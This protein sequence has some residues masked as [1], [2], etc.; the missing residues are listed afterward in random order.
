MKTY[1]QFLFE[2]PQ[3]KTPSDGGNTLN[4]PYFNSENGMM[5]NNTFRKGSK[6]LSKDN[7]ITTVKIGD[8]YRVRDDDT[9]QVVFMS[10]I[11]RNRKTKQIPFAHNT[12]E[13]VAKMSNSILP[14]RFGAN[15]VYNH[16]IMNKN[17]PFVSDEEQYPGG[18]KM[19]HNLIDRAFKEG[20]HAYHIHK[21]VLTKITPE[22]KE[23]IMKSS[24]GYSPKF[25]EHR[26][27][28][29]KTEL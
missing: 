28:I 3:M 19:W 15:F 29:S 2:M 27:M 24:Y 9:K 8:E 20:H 23:E 25:K 16:F 12:Q 26:Y 13:Y 21:G 14:K 17:I 4:D 11:K 5:Y 10:N 7:N 22:N 1:K 6:I 18:H